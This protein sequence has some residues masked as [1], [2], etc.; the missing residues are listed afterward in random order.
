MRPAA[1]RFFAKD[2]AGRATAWAYRQASRGRRLLEDPQRRLLKRQADLMRTNPVLHV[3]EFGGDFELF[4][5]SH[6]Y[7]R[8]LMRG[9]YEPELAKL[10]YD[11]LD[12]VKDAIDVGAN[13]GFYTVMMANRLQGQRVLSIEPVPETREVL[14]RNLEINSLSNVEVAAV[15]VGSNRGRGILS[16][17]PNQPEYSSLGEITHP[18]MHDSKTVDIPIPVDTIDSLVATYGLDV[19]FIKLDIEGGELEALKGAKSTLLQQRPAILMETAQSLLE[20]KGASVNQLLEFM[21]DHNYDVRDALH[22]DLPLGQGTFSDTLA[23]P[24]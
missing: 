20:S 17:S 10:A 19:G 3:E 9:D 22:P 23:L 21:E 2:K 8:I 13:V 12:P 15:A 14:T 16:V 5:S 1:S 7:S 6:L 18:S 4:A 11:N 24:K